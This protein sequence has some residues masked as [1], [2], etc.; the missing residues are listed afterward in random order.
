MKLI[1]D[2][3]EVP[4]KLV[5]FVQTTPATAVSECPAQRIPKDPKG[6]HKGNQ[7]SPSTNDR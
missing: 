2:Y 1:R 5:G 7:Q 3:K 4:L 6:R